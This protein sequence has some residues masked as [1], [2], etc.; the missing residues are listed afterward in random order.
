MGS[1]A[2]NN[3]VRVCVEAT[4]FLTTRNKESTPARHEAQDMSWQTLTLPLVPVHFYPVSHIKTFI[5]TILC[6]RSYRIVHTEN[7]CYM[8]GMQSPAKPS[9]PPSMKY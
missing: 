9:M 3:V 7:C 8:N 6:T 4:S 2:L 1:F 5:C